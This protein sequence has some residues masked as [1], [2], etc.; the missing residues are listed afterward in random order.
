MF[1][2]ITRP[3]DPPHNG[4]CP[5][6]HHTNQKVIDKCSRLQRQSSTYSSSD[7]KANGKT[8]FLLCDFQGGVQEYHVS[9]RGRTLHETALH[10]NTPKESELSFHK[11]KEHIFKLSG[12]KCRNRPARSP[13]VE[14]EL[15]QFLKVAR[16]HRLPVTG[17]IIMSKPTHNRG[18]LNLTKEM[19]KVSRGWFY[20]FLQ[21]NGISK[22]V[23]LY[24][25]AGPV[26]PA[27]VREQMIKVCNILRKYDPDQIYNRDE[28]GFLYN[29]LPNLTY[30]VP[31]ETEKDG[32][33]TKAM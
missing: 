22:K 12:A 16:A 4:T 14:A 20:R 19:F 30:L 8:P 27:A 9:V 25:E 29:H 5:L 18:T 28:F 7:F 33:I 24:G 26:N 2:I 3:S 23:R 10:F 31:E 21:R 15:L 17:A 1:P 6:N 11:R 32:R 13:H